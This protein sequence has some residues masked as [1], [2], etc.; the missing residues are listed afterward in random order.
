[1]KFKDLAIEEQDFYRKRLVEYMKNEYEKDF[2]G[3]QD[4]RSRHI[5]ARDKAWDD[6]LCMDEV[7]E[8]LSN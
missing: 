8:E 7:K 3:N 5:W 6:V 4:G 2:R 1:M